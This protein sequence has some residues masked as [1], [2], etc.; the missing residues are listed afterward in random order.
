MEASTRST[1]YEAVTESCDNNIRYFDSDETNLG[2]KINGAFVGINYHLKILQPLS[3]E[4]ELFANN[5]DFEDTPGNG[6]S[7]FLYVT[8]M[9][10]R[11]TLKTTNYVTEYR[12]SLLFRKQIYSR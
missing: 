4:V 10:L 5:Y 7:S 3:Y 9:S 2:L 6:F 12:D 11:H 8:D 1:L